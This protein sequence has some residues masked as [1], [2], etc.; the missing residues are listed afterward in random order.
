[1]ALNTASRMNGI[2]LAWNPSTLSA[3]TE[4]ISA[5]VRPPGEETTN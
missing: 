3:F 1:M 2:V 4:L 5:P